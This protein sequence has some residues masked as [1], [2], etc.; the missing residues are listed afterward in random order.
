MGTQTSK[1]PVDVKALKDISKKKDPKEKPDIQAL[2][3]GDGAQKE[4]SAAASPPE[5]LGCLDQGAVTGEEAIACPEPPAEKKDPS[6]QF[7]ITI[8][9]WW[10][11]QL[12]RRTL[13]HATLSV[14]VIQRWWHQ[15]AFKQ[16][17]ERR[18]KELVTYMRTERAIVLLQSL[19]RRW[20]ARTQYKKYQKAA[21]VLQNS[22]RRYIYHRESMGWAGKKMADEAV[23]LFIEIAVG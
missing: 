12:V 7:A 4:S 19:V 16:R 15:V 8:Q 6:D 17:E 3:G 10:R 21:L 14:L 1:A 11:G 13:H 18:V 22:W 9:S 2:A 23:D 20:L 5:Q